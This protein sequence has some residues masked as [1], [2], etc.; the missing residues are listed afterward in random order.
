MKR[1]GRGTAKLGDIV[2]VAFDEA[3]RYTKDPAEVAR[4]A[5]KA[6]MHLVKRS[7]VVAPRAGAPR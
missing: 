4:L 1:H 2:V 7:F 6:V 3:A 5:T